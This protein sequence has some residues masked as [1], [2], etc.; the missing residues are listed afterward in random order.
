MVQEAP[1]QSAFLIVEDEPTALRSLARL[2]RRYRPTHGALTTDEADELLTRHQ[3]W[4]GFVVDVQLRPGSGLD[5]LERARERHPEVPALVLTAHARREYINRAFDLRAEYACKPVG[6]DGLVPF[7]THALAVD[8]AVDERIA[9]I[10]AGFRR[11][12]G[13]SVSE[14]DVLSLAVAGRSR[15]EIARMRLVSMNTLK[16]QIRTLLTKT[17][18]PNLTSLARRIQRTAV[19]PRRPLPH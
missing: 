8:S 11:T 2:F 5:V 3:A 19:R 17:G 7:I 4:C 6:H 12:F 13:L 9:R 16:T 14:V 1:T 18:E 10:V 15:S